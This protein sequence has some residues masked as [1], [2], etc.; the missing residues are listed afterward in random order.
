MTGLT[1][2][3]HL[4]VPTPATLRLLLNIP[5]VPGPKGA[6]G[7]LVTP[8]GAS[9]VKALAGGRFGQPPPFVPEAVGAWDVGV[10][11]DRRLSI[12]GNGE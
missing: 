10:S 2:H 9:L 5:T 1:A 4:P 7:E 12:V 6:V 3:G 11:I 8:T